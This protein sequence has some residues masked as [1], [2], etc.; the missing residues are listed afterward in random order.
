MVTLINDLEQFTLL[1]LKISL[2]ITKRGRIERNRSNLN[3]CIVSRKFSP[4]P[5]TVKSSRKI[6]HL[7]TNPTDVLE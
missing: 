2:N 1:E 7:S 4:R 5:I 3:K 6:S